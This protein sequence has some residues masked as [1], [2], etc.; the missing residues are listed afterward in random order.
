MLGKNKGWMTVLIILTAYK[1]FSGSKVELR[2][3]REPGTEH[4]SEICGLKPSEKVKL[5]KDAKGKV[6]LSA[7][8]FK[9]F[10]KQMLMRDFAVA[11]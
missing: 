9:R 8:H 1:L 4:A 10:S 11:L 2:L 6:S 3:K 7:P 5:E